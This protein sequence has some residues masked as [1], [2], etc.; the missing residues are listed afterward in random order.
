MSPSSERLTRINV[1]LY[2]RD[3]EIMRFHGIPS[4]SRSKPMENRPIN[5]LVISGKRDLDSH[6]RRPR[7]NNN[8][9]A[10]ADDESQVPTSKDTRPNEEAPRQDTQVCGVKVNARSSSKLDPSREQP[11]STLSGPKAINRGRAE[12]STDASRAYLSD[13]QFIADKKLEQLK[14]SAFHSTTSLIPSLKQASQAAAASSSPASTRRRLI[15]LSHLRVPLI[16]VGE[17]S[18]ALNSKQSGAGA[19]ASCRRQRLANSAPQQ[20]QQQQ[21]AQVTVS[22]TTRNSHLR[23]GALYARRRAALNSANIAHTNPAHSNKSAHLPQ[24]KSAPIRQASINLQAEL[25]KKNPSYHLKL[26]VSNLNATIVNNANKHHQQQPS[27]TAATTPTFRRRYNHNHSHSHLINAASGSLGSLLLS[28]APSFVRPPPPC[29][30]SSVSCSSSSKSSLASSTSSLAASTTQS[31]LNTRLANKAKK[32]LPSSLGSRPEPGCPAQATVSC[33]FSGS[34]SR[35]P[36]PKRVALDQVQVDA[37][38]A[39]ASVKISAPRPLVIPLR[40]RPNSA[41]QQP[42]T[43]ATAAGAQKQARANGSEPRPPSNAQTDREQSTQPVEKN[44]KPDKYNNNNNNNNNNF[45]E[46]QLQLELDKKQISVS[47]DNQNQENEINHS[48]RTNIEKHNYL[49]KSHPNSSFMKAN[50]TNSSIREPKQQEKQQRKQ[51]HSSSSLSSSLSSSSIVTIDSPSAT[52]KQHQQADECLFSTVILDDDNNNN[53]NSD[54]IIIM[55]DTCLN[56][57]SQSHPFVY[58]DNDYHNNHINN[59]DNINSNDMKTTTGDRNNSSADI[60]N[61]AD[62][63]TTCKGLSSSPCSSTLLKRSSTIGCGN[64]D[65]LVSPKPFV[66]QPLGLSQAD[67]C[68]FT[69]QNQSSKTIESNNNTIITHQ[70]DPVSNGAI[71]TTMTNNKLQ[72]TINQQQQQKLITSDNVDIPIRLDSINDLYEMEARPFARGKF[73]QVKRCINKSTMECFA[74][75]CIKKRRR[76]VDMRNEILLEIEALK[77][78]YLNEYIV[79][80]YHV[81]ETSSEMILLL[82]MANGG[83]LQRL[84]DEEEKL[85][86]LCVKQI[87]SQILNGLICLHQNDIAHLD[88]KPQNILLTKPYPNCHIKLCDFGMSRKIS[89]DSELREICGTPDYVAPE[90][91]RYDPITLTTDMWSLGILTYVLLSGYSPFGGDTKQQTFCNITQAPLDFPPECFETITGDAIDFMCKLI[92][93]DPKIRL[94]SKQADSHDWFRSK[95]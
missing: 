57:T 15:N 70:H 22:A 40:R 53:N 8:N 64:G 69:P 19:E 20:Q 59:I 13:N 52:S 36:A 1:M 77:L 24:H 37:S 61:A 84:V 35:R 31:S 16:N 23:R 68:I 38:A 66:S 7:N 65:C 85:D 6:R 4:G 80:I 3:Q 21:K 79:K 58:N 47:I 82:E 94:T 42:P 51:A 46:S 28:P 30:S 73:A 93:R 14:L 48:T 50:K 62:N 9:D 39:C 89:K 83:E 60:M 86:E 75:K 76:L 74:A 45:N 78:S 32:A 95:S 91:L 29:R 71:D 81:Y 33:C 54:K 12:L 17:K 67:N 43:K 49:T 87:I 34:S 56:T 2:D 44:R 26:N 5:T 10:D 63:L 72:L 27:S 55:N 25:K 18:S 92:V 88:I 41:T 11:G 90:I